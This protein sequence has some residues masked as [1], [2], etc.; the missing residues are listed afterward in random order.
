MAGKRKPYT[1]I[2]FLLSIYRSLEALQAENREKIS[3]KSSWAFRPRV[4]KNGIALWRAARHCLTFLASPP[5]VPWRPGVPGVPF[6]RPQTSRP[7][8][9]QR[10]QR[11]RRPRPL[12]IPNV[13]VV[14]SFAFISKCQWMER[15]MLALCTSVGGLFWGIALQGAQDARTTIFANFREFSQNFHKNLLQKSLPFPYGFRRV[16]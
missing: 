10:P 1:S 14:I 7:R 13:G 15:H 3:K 5:G 11:L 2:A 16:M 9:P 12:I 6:R 8:H 4:S